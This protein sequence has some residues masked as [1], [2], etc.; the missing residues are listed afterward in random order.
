MS[1]L[2]NNIINGIT[3]YRIA[4][5][6][7]LFVLIFTGKIELFKWLLAVSFFTD[8][9]DG[10]LARKYKVTSILGSRLDSIGDDLT[11]LA[12]FVGLIVF[13]REFFREELIALIILFALFI[14]QNIFAIV[15]YRKIT[16]FHTYLAKT[17]A[18]LQGL[19]FIQMF[20]L[21]QPFYFLFYAAAFVTGIE[22]I[23]ETLIVI[24]LPT[25]EANVKGLYWVLKRKK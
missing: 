4:A 25:W 22:L 20:L 7:L 16:S 23:E 10:Y 18:I 17:A 3:I 21:P 15:R 12:A 14:V 6:P 13:K 5:A 9:I 1:K 19:F 24:A 2:S 8:F 11:V